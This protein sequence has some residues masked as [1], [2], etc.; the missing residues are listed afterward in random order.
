ML[1]VCVPRMYCVFSTVLQARSLFGC[2][3]YC[4]VLTR[5]W[6]HNPPLF[7]QFSDTVRTPGELQFI[8]GSTINI[9]QSF[10]TEIRILLPILRTESME[11]LSLIK[12][13]PVLLDKRIFRLPHI[14]FFRYYL[15]RA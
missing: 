4:L 14:A 6:L 7:H 9:K 13:C 1:S 11:S 15:L 3:A 12:L 10:E 5:T 2:Y 8:R